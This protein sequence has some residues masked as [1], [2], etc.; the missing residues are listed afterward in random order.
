MRN[1]LLIVTASILLVGCFETTT[2]M[3]EPADLKVD[4][5]LVGDWSFPADG[6]AKAFTLVN[7]N[8][9]D[10]HYYVEYKEDEQEPSRMVGAVIT[11][12]NAKFAQLRE[13]SNDGSIPEKHSIMRVSFENE[14]LG[15]RQLSEDF[16][17][18]H[19]F[20]DGEALRKLI[21]ENV[22]NEKMYDGGF[23]Y[24]TKKPSA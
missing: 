18:E 14:K 1:L 9:D 11:I 17:K 3:P 24:G 21:E 19:T 20:Q 2:P 8:I 6:D 16:F 13:L 22:E 4:R 15:V 10:K 7:R 5:S 23:R 12:K